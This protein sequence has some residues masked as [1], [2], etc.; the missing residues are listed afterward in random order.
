V[1]QIRNTSKNLPDAIAAMTDG[2]NFDLVLLD[3]RMPGVKGLDS[4]KRVIDIGS[5]ARTTLFTANADRH[6]VRRATELGV[7]A[8][9]QNTIPLNS[10]ESVLRLILSGQTFLHSS[11][12]E[13]PA[14]GRAA[15]P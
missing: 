11:L 7:H 13:A 15:K 2:P 3:P 9:I 4:L 1:A 5:G 14:T 8:V 6:I 10:I 12:I